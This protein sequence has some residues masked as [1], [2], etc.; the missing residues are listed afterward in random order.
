MALLSA[1]DISKRFGGVTALDE[2]SFSCEAGEIHALL[3]GNGAGKSTMVK[4][5]CGVVEPDAGTI[6]LDGRA[7][8]FGS[9]AQANAA[10]VIS[11]FQELS[12]VPDLTIAE[13]LFLQREPTRFGLVARGAM[14]R[15]TTELLASLEFPAIDPDVC[16]RDL[17]LADRQLVEIAKAI[18]RNPRV[19]VLDEATSALGAQEVIRLFRVL[20]RLKEQG[21]AIIFISHRM[22][23]VRSICDR[24]TIFR[25]GK[26][27][28]TVELATASNEQ[29]LRMMV[30]REL[31]EVFPDKPAPPEHP[32]PALE[33]EHLTWEPELRDVSFTVNRGEIL[34]LA[35]LEGQGQGEL[36]LSLFGVHAGVSGTVKV[37]GKPVSLKSPRGA[38]GAHTALI[39]EDRKTQGLILPL[40]VETNMLLPVLPAI[41]RLGVVDRAREAALTGSM[42]DQLA[43][44]TPSADVPVA[45]LSGGNQQKTAIAKWLLTDAQIYLM[46][47]PTRGIDVATKHEIYR[48]LRALADGGAAILLFSTD[49]AELIGLCDRALV[50][51]EGAIVRA[52]TGAEITRENLISS[53]LGM[54]REELDEAIEVAIEDEV[55]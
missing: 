35:G 39:P 2:A 54:R 9:P 34:G 21:T 4:I 10:G 3:G 29:I 23:E 5:I 14:R 25:D 31:K 7:V 22:E 53:A 11:V 37:D 48:L 46:Y 20:H 36:L 42:I 38:M 18:S 15:Q 24:A 12:L 17:A 27:V 40:T 50:M 30:G 13:N 19:L 52:L 26:T 47:D 44:K 28:G 8:T 6:D 43:I 33:V 16:A 32:V 51:Y 55:A 45:N 41:S 1:T 49:A